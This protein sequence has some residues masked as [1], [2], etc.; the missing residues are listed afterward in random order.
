MQ[1]R[2]R[3]RNHHK[4]EHVQYGGE[5]LSLVVGAA[6]IAPNASTKHVSHLVRLASKPD[7]RLPLNVIF[8]DEGRRILIDVFGEDPSLP[9]T[10]R[11][12]GQHHHLPIHPLEMP[13]QIGPIPNNTAMFPVPAQAMAPGQHSV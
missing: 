2:H 9:K 12:P 5:A 3:P 1:P 10:K 13:T 11:L 7:Q 6:A 4:N 8:P